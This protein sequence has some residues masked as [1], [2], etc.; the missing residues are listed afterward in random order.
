MDSTKPR[1]LDLLVL[2]AGRVGLALARVARSKGMEVQVW[3]RRPLDFV[4]NELVLKW[5]V[6]LAI[7]EVP[8]PL[9]G[10]TPV[11]VALPD[12]ALLPFLRSLPDAA[13]L[14]ATLLITSGGMELP[15]RVGGHS[16]VRFHPPFSFP[17]VDLPLEVLE[18]ACAVVVGDA[19]GVAQGVALA[20]ALG[21]QSVSAPR[22]NAG[23]YHAGCVFASNLTAV[24]LAA[25]STCLT[26][27]GLVDKSQAAVLASLLR[28]PLRN[29]PH[30]VA[31]FSGPASRGDV[32]TLSKE[33]A[34]LAVVHP[35]LVDLFRAGNALI[36]KL[37]GHEELSEMLKTGTPD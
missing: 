10:P 34:A 24:C 14:D 33:L 11:V 31:S 3:N 16:V 18:K 2:G 8:P 19:T 12:T 15:E 9:Q 17:A 29:L 4:R 7:S 20:E 25:A 23:W 13:D 6:P 28:G 30:S 35:E 32:A 36:A 27:A 22:L 1:N 21:W 26:Q 5:G 37:S